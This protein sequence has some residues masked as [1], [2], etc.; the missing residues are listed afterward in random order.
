MV[1]R[2]AAANNAAAKRATIAGWRTRFQN[3]IDMLPAWLDPGGRVGLGATR[4]YF[5]P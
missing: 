5:D 1:P 4:K 3:D 2:Q